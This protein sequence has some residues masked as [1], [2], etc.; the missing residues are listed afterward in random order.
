MED[1]DPLR[2][3]WVRAPEERGEAFREV[4]RVRHCLDCDP[5]SIF[6]T[7]RMR[8]DEKTAEGGRRT[9]FPNGQPAYPNADTLGIHPSF[10]IIVT[11]R[12]PRMGGGARDE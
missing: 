5:S 2:P 7:M 12:R 4:C 8:E 3:F 6:C 10:L 9:Q 1:E 11:W